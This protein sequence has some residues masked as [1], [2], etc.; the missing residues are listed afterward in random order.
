MKCVCDFDGTLEILPLLSNKAQSFN[1]V[2]QVLNSPEL[3]IAKASD[4][5]WL[6][7]ERCI[8][9]V[10]ASYAAIVVVLDN[11]HESTHDPEAL[12]LSRALSKQSAGTAMYVLDYILPQVGKPTRIL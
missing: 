6:T 1:M 7:H 3:K 8:K 5:H 12:E 9:T 2:Q 10:K 4:T 11:I